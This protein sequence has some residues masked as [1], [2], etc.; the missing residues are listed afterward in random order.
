[1]LSGARV[2]KEVSMVG[3]AAGAVGLL[4]VLRVG[5]PP[6]PFTGLKALRE[7]RRLGGVRCAFQLFEESRE[8]HKNSF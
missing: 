5:C 1:M 4:R 7:V 3:V 6:R 8:P 2:F